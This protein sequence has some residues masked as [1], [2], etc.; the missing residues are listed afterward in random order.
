MR[1]TKS[2]T[3]KSDGATGTPLPKKL[4]LLSSMPSQEVVLVGAP[5]SFRA[6]LGEL[7]AGLRFA[8]RLTEKTSLAICFVRTRQELA[9]V[10]E[11][12]EAGLQAG[13]SAW[14]CRPKSHLKPDVSEQDVRDVGLAHGLVDYKICS[15]D[16]NWSGMK[17]A[18]RKAQAACESTGVRG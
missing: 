6:L 8:T 12:L 16:E 18:R 2:T 5:E 11:M 13:A 4:G 9:P 15:V 3:A 17:F 7:P 14:I 10:V 1:T